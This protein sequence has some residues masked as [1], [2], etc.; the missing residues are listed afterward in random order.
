MIQK[1][2]ICQ[3]E[4]VKLALVGRGVYRLVEKY[5]K[6]FFILEKL[7]YERVDMRLK[8]LNSFNSFIPVVLP[9]KDQSAVYVS[10]RSN[11]NI[12]KYNDKVYDVFNK[13]SL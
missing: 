7:Y 12:M 11:K 6:D 13:Q 1:E 10:E 8:T 5:K 9:F 2:G 3:Q 4:K